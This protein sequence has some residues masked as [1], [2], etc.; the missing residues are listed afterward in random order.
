MKSLIKVLLVVCIQFQIV[1]PTLAQE[2]FD[3]KIDVSEL[4]ITPNA[5]TNKYKGIEV[6][7]IPN[8]YSENRD[9]GWHT[10]LFYVD[11]FVKGQKIS[12]V[13]EASVSATMRNNKL[14]GR[15]S[16]FDKEIFIPYAYLDLENGKHTIELVL[17]GDVGDEKVEFGRKQIIVDFKKVQKHSYADQR[18]T[19][20]N[21]K[22]NFNE[23]QWGT[24]YKGIKIE[25]DCDFL[26][27]F[28]QI[29]NSELSEEYGEYYIYPIIK[30]EEGEI[31]YPTSF[32]KQKR[33]KA[34][35]EYDKYGKKK[36]IDKYIK[37][38]VPYKDINKEG[39]FIANLEII[40]ENK[41]GSVVLPILLKRKIEI[42]KPIT[43]NFEDQ[44]FA[45]SSVLA[46]DKITTLG[47][48]GIRVDFRCKFKFA[49]D[50][51]KGIDTNE[52]MKSYYFYLVIKD[53]QGNVVYSPSLVKK[54]TNGQEALCYKITP[55]SPPGEYKEVSFIIPYRLLN[56]QEGIH[57]LKGQINATNYN[58]SADFKGLAKFEMEVDFP[59]AS[60]NNLQVTKLEAV[61]GVYDVAGKN[62][63]I[64]NLFVGKKSKAGKGYPDVMWV[65]KNGDEAIYRAPTRNNSFFGAD[66]S[67]SFKSMIDESVTFT[68]YDRDITSRHDLLGSF[69][70]KGCNDDCKQLYTDTGFAKVKNVTLNFVKKSVPKINIKENKVG[71]SKL[72]GMSG[73]KAEISYF[74]ENLH[75]KDELSIEPL[76]ANTHAYRT[77][78]GISF[79]DKGKI[80]VPNSFTIT[81]NN[82]QG[83][84][85]Y[86]IPLYLLGNYEDLI[87]AF[88]FQPFDLPVYA[89]SYQI[90]QTAKKVND[91][92][93]KVDIFP[94]YQNEDFVGIKL[95]VTHEVPSS[96]FLNGNPQILH[97]LGFYVNKEGLSNRI[98]ELTEYKTIKSDVELN[99]YY[100]KE[101]KFS[102][103]FFI[104]YYKL[105]P[106]KSKQSLRF[107][108]NTQLPKHNF[109]IGN[110]SKTTEI[111]LPKLYELKIQK[112]DIQ[113]KKRKKYKYMLWE[114]YHGDQLVYRTE[115]KQ[116]NEKTI[117]WEKLPAE[118]IICHSQDKIHLYLF[119][120]DSKGRESLISV[121]DFSGGE[122]YRS[123]ST[124]KID[125]N[126]KIKK[127]EI[128]FFIK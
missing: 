114:V 121:W 98:E 30:D 72:E 42:L 12:M 40:A 66:G 15:K 58:Q 53:N 47:Q 14:S 93:T 25:F 23:L 41:D 125:R 117:H 19:L 21:I 104:P 6:S 71:I 43:Y 45:V 99:N 102:R 2:K 68:A 38:F 64:V 84:F 31:I 67:H 62:I 74:V 69:K 91:T 5:I 90:P 48:K 65:I 13:K 88:S 11:V 63:P 32:D 77:P 123:T 33:I 24:D 18:I 83:K 76:F 87:T 50:Q 122:F 4:K 115:P 118:T 103:D 49:S 8:F 112:Y 113:I 37:L 108:I 56:L 70:F 111:E 73:L 127:G 128:Q 101:S 27:G 78:Q 96:Y 22:L 35:P 16:M 26:Y 97:N 89:L 107:E 109:E 110:F 95:S 85:E 106:L 105:F 94:N 81:S 34:E 51:I 28:D 126:T 75:N 116:N 36:P 82:Y 92:K 7:F 59:K 86:F 17:T 55:A 20:Q 119:G 39:A 46:K 9:D 124:M 44:E 80:A 29:Y 60:I 61:Y 52:N 1:I 54:V 3:G 57:K 120:H 100:S 10:M 79:I